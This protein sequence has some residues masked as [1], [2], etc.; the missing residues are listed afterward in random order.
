MPSSLFNHIM[1]AYEYF[2]LHFKSGTASE[3]EREWGS[4][5]CSVFDTASR[6]VY[7]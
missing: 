1:E 4:L 6:V 3:G 7:C 2:I 5:F